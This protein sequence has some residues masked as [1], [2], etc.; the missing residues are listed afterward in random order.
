MKFHYFNSTHWDREWYLPMQNFRYRL[1]ATA[2]RILNGLEDEK[3][4]NKY[5]FDGQTVVLEDICEIKPEEAIRITKAIKA[6]KLN[7]GPWYV[8]PDEFLVSGESLIRNL[9]MGKEVA[10]KFGG[11]PWRIGYICDIFGHIAQMPQIF[12]GFNIDVTVLWRGVHADWEPFFFWEA[13]DGS[14]NGIVKLFPDNGY[15]NFSLHVTGQ[16]DIPLDEKEFKANMAEVME[17]LTKHY[18][19]DI[20]LSD[21]IDHSEPHPDVASIEKWV[22]EMY[23]GSEFIHSDYMEFYDYFK[24]H[25]DLPVRKGE[26][27]VTRALGGTPMIPHTLSSRYDIKAGNDQIQNRFELDIDPLMAREIANGRSFSAP[28]WKYAWKQFLKNHPHDSICGCSVDAVHRQMFARYEEIHQVGNSIYD[29]L[30]DADFLA[31]TGKDIRTATNKLR[32]MEGVFK[33]TDCAEDGNYTFRIFNA[34]PFEQEKILSLELPFSC[35]K[36][37]PTHWQEPFGYQNLNAF[38]LYDADGNEIPYKMTCVKR[39]Q[40]KKFYYQDCRL[41]DI[42]TVTCRCR[43]SASGWTA[44]QVKPVQDS[45]RFFGSQLINNNGAENALLKLTVEDDGSLTIFD[46]KRQKTYSKLNL[47][48][49]DRDIG[50]GWNMVHPVENRLYQRGACTGVTVVEDGPERSVFAVDYA[51]NLPKEMIYSGTVNEGYGGIRESEEI[52]TLKLRSF[53]TLDAGSDAV[54]IRTEVDNNVCDCRVKVRIPT[55]ISGNYYAAQA[56]GFIERAPG[57]ASGN[58]TANWPESEPLEKNMA[59]LA[60]KRDAVGGI[61][62]VGKYGLHEIAASDGSDGTLF[63]TL[64]RCF[65]HTVMT[66]GEMDGELQKHLTFEYALKLTGSEADYYS[67]NRFAQEYRSALFS[68]M[69]PAAMVRNTAEDAPFIQIKGGLSYSALKPAQNLQENTVI[70]RVVNLS[71]TIQ[72]STVELCAEAEIT[73]VNLAE[74]SIGSAVKAKEFTIEATPWQIKTYQITFLSR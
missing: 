24:E 42:Y 44:I 2:E 18:N 51:Y 60:G 37:Y 53:I 32:D 72:Q 55:G 29:G 6:G 56:F 12:K 73:P 45:V 13:P 35:A 1:V 19:E 21:A 9:L 40:Q 69:L 33:V 74:E 57:R 5:T 49:V 28:F 50:D 38:R 48:E 23:P 43:L 62:F 11:S 34:L 3:G 17:L 59:N 67:L 58:E 7:I 54:L 39:N 20:I 4:F 14:R 8:M 27:I 47:F 46:K 30:M 61:A 36:P 68:Y 25:S 26:F 65:R 66:N 31:V 41:Y 63:V 15:G 52:V 71:G 64:Y 22:K 16:Y 70:L 10:E